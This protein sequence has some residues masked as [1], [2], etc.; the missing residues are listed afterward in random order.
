[1]IVNDNMVYPLQEYDV[2]LKI[3][4]CTSNECKGCRVVYVWI[5]LVIAYS[6]LK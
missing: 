6:M 5:C 4:S 1:M 2:D 3:E